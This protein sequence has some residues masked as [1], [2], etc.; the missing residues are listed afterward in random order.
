LAIIL[1][2]CAVAGD[3]E[4]D[5]PHCPPEI[6]HVTHHQQVMSD[7]DCGIGDQQN[8]ESRSLKTNPKDS[9]NM[10]PVAIVNESYTFDARISGSQ[11]LLNPSGFLVPS[12]PPLNV[13]HCVYLK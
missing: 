6:S 4:H 5:C 12:G 7:S 2:P 11:T 8:L 1:Q 9:T 3:I 10:V 13:L